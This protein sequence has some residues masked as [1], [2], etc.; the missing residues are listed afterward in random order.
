MGFGVYSSSGN[1]YDSRNKRET[2]HSE[3]KYDTTNS[4]NLKNLK[5]SFKCVD[6]EIVRKVYRGEYGNGKERKMRLEK[7]G[8]NYSSVQKQVNNTY[9]N[10]KK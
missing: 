10:K 1:C 8:Y 9:Y 2:N 7:E 3:H 5:P 6:K 4:I